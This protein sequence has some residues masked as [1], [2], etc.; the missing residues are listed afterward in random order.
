MGKNM[1]KFLAVAAALTMVI[2]LLLT[3]CVSTN[4]DSFYAM[5]TYCSFEI[6]GE[7]PGIE[8]VVRKVENKLSHRIDTSM[9]SRL[10]KGDYVTDND[11]LVD[12]IRICVDVSKLTNGKYTVFS[13]PITSLWNFDSE[14]PTVPS[15]EQL[16]TA[17]NKSQKPKIAVS[18]DGKVALNAGKLDLGSLGKGYACE[19]A[20]SACKLSG[21]ESALISIGGSLGMYGSEYKIAVR[22][23]FGSSTDVYGTLTLSTGFVS[24]SG[25]YEKNFT[26]DGVLY[27]H[28]IDA[29]T[30]YPVDSEFASVTVYSASGTMSDMLSTACYLLSYDKASSLLKQYGCEALFIFKDGSYRVTG[31]LSPFFEYSGDKE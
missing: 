31:G 29:T 24:T 12:L 28:I 13:L 14:N 6:T 22:D 18:E 23:P 30:G 21:V 19:A 10:N 1:N 4:S 17:V 26:V 8:A 5:G 9:V 3:S 27:H 20:L 15:E 11:G 25:A 16:K 2:G 7:D